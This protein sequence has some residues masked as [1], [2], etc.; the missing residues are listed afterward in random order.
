MNAAPLNPEIHCCAAMPGR[1]ET[2]C[3]RHR[4]HADE[5]GDLGH[6]QRSADG[7]AR[8][9][10]CAPPLATVESLA[11]DLSSALLAARNAAPEGTPAHAALAKFERDSLALYEGIARLRVE[12]PAA[13]VTR[14]PWTETRCGDFLPNYERDLCSSCERGFGPRESMAGGAPI[15][16]KRGLERHP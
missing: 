8:W 13:P 4:G 9:P 16:C 14:V 3:G 1:P 7:G 5:P 10:S 15:G 12:L 11:L 6:R 2:L